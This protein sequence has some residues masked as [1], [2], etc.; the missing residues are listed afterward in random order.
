MERLILGCSS[1]VE[2]HRRDFAYLDGYVPSFVDAR[3]DEVPHDACDSTVSCLDPQPTSVA[4]ERAYNVAELPKRR[5]VAGAEQLTACGEDPR[6]GEHDQPHPPIW[7][8]PAWKLANN[9]VSRLDKAT[10]HTLDTLWALA[11]DEELRTNMTIG[12][13]RSSDGR[14]QDRSTN[15][16]SR[17]ALRGSRRRCR[18]GRD[19]R[20]RLRSPPTTRT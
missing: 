8:P 14:D 5:F 2:R 17:H 19:P 11:G 16:T 1:R 3:R 7:R 20:S 10:L 12:V 4:Q 13:G 9:L 6:D 18:R 15:I